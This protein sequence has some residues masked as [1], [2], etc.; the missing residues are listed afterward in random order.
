MEN[1]KDESTLGVV[2]ISD[3]VVSVYSGCRCFLCI[4]LLLAFLRFL[5]CVR[6][7][8][9]RLKCCLCV[10]VFL[11]FKELFCRCIRFL[12]CGLFLSGQLCCLRLRSAVGCISVIAKGCERFDSSVV[13]SNG[14]QLFGGFIGSPVFGLLLCLLFLL[15]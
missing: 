14:Q 8:S 7:F 5:L 15:L 10:G 1:I 3:E 11:F 9:K 12:I 6:I 2:R 4:Q 13:I